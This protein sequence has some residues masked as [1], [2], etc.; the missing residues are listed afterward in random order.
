VHHWL[1]NAK[2]KGDWAVDLPTSPGQSVNVYVAPQTA[3]VGISTKVDQIGA[4][5]SGGANGGSFVTVGI[6]SGSLR[7][8]SITYAHI[9]PTVRVGQSLNRWG[10][11][12]GTV[13]GSLP[14]NK[15]CW[16]APHVHLQMFSNRHYAC[17][18]RAYTH[19]YPVHR[20]NFVGFTGG[21]KASLPRQACP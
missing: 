13:A 9:I 19:N 6:Y 7:V 14:V 8:G 18:N 10:A 2:D 1:G 5:C 20:T 4:G 3:S 15:A 11:V 17:Y 12:V 21:N 16:T